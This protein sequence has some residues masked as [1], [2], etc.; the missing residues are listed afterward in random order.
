MFKTFKHALRA[1]WIIVLVWAG[2]ARAADRDYIVKAGDTLGSIAQEHGVTTSALQE[3][4]YIVNPDRLA[5]GQTLRIP[6]NPSD[7]VRY[8]VARGDTLSGI[9]QAHGVTTR[10]I[11]DMNTIRDADRLTIGQELRIPGPGHGAASSAISLALRREL[12]AVRVRRGTWRFVI[13]HHS[14]TTRGNVRDMD[15][16]HREERRMENGLAYHFVIGN[17]N[18]MGDG[19]IAI[20]PRWKKQLEGGHLASTAQNRISIGICLVGNFEESRPSPRQM[21]SLKDLVHYL[22]IRCG[23]DKSRVR[24]HRQVNIRPTVCPGKYFPTQSFVGGLAP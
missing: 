15:R 9:A 5:V 1:L 19:E 21:K 3:A 6:P 20:G 12:A 16:Y 23:I 11:L 4:N 24:T 2:T 22:Q 10:A 13:I 18:G 8:V 14:G 17:G 7:P